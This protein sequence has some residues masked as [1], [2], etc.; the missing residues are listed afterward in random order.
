MK[1]RF[2][3]VKIR[4]MIQTLEA[5]VDETGKIRMLAEIHLKKSPWA[6]LVTILDEEWKG[7]R[8]AKKTNQSGRHL[9]A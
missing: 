1:S 9:T 2:L 7:I 4:I 5:I 3:Y 8:A 6:L